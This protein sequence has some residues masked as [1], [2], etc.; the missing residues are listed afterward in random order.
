MNLK[1]PGRKELKV[2]ARFSKDSC[3]VACNFQQRN[4]AVDSSEGS[5]AKGKRRRL[6]DWHC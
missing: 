6:C 1:L 3:I 2:A 5:K 4:C